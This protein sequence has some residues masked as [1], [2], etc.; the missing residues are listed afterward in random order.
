MAQQSL[1]A[2]RSLDLGLRGCGAHPEHGVEAACV[3]R[4]H[5]SAER[6]CAPNASHS[7]PAEPSKDARK[8]LFKKLISV[9]VGVEQPAV[10]VRHGAGDDGLR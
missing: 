3:H 9:L 6:L 4:V 5:R 7:T 2:V 10:L 1:G 8:R